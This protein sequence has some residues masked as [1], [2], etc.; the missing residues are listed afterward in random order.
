MK[1]IDAYEFAD[2]NPDIQKK[3]REEWTNQE[4]ENNLEFLS[5]ELNKGNLDEENFYHALGCSKSYAETTSWFVPACYYEHNQEV[6]DDSVEQTLKEMLF[7]A[8]GK[9]IQM[10]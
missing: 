5:A 1:Q 10:K 9:F 2:L 7:T 3:V 6:I 4:V 8:S